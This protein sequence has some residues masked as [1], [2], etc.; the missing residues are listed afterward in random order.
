MEES[1]N[2]LDSLRTFELHRRQT[3]FKAFENSRLFWDA[4][5][6]Y[7]NEGVDDVRDFICNL[8]LKHNLLCSYASNLE[9]S[10]Q[11]ANA[12]ANESVN[13]SKRKGIACNKVL[14]SLDENVCTNILNLKAGIEKEIVHLAT[15]LECLCTELKTLWM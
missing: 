7:Q 9:L 6:E 8:T 13:K 1:W 10:I 11:R 4:L 2:I 14:A 5:K 12:L 15:V 3:H